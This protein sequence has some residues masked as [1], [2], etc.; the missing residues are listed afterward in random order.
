MPKRSKFPR[1]R[2]YVKRGAGGK[3]WVS[4]AYDMRGTG[5][6]DVPLG[7]DYDEALRRW[8]EIALDR[9][10]IRGTLEEGFGEWE[11]R[12]M[13]ARA[14]G[15]PRKPL[16][17]EGYRKCLKE[18]R[19]VFGPA[20]WAE[21]TMPALRAYVDKRSA[22]ARAK[23]EMQLLAVIW[24]WCVMEGITDLRWPA[25]DL[26]RSGWQ[27]ATRRRQIEV[28][29]DSLAAL[30]KHADQ[31]LRDALDIATATG[32]RV[33]D[34]IG[35][36]VS[37]ARDGL[38]VV[39]AGKTGKRAE[40]PIVGSVLADVIKRRQ[41]NRKAEH[42]FLLTAGRRPVTYRRLEAR[43]TKARAAAALEVPAVAALI[44]RDM[45]KRAAQQAGTLA[46][47]SALLQHS[48]LSVTRN[49]YR[50]GDRIKPVR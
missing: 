41:E 20:T 42:L 3:V 1:F 46:E 2:T 17:I 24:R 28:G 32:L 38:L 47:A 25:S 9:P 12:G 21:V 48:S 14:D 44:L 31:T 35:L 27:G 7:T 8:A 45:R 39:D 19:A 30:Y 18:L 11:K 22:K 26:G 49:H 15:T 34:V 50:Q 16:T 6:P 13:A 10:R 4:Y 37:D 5:K 43:F 29:D 40:F 33:L 36:R 23:Q